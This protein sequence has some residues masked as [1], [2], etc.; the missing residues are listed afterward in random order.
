MSPGSRSPPAR[1]ARF[2]TTNPPAPKNTILAAVRRPYET[3]SVPFAGRP[4]PLAHV[5]TTSARSALARIP[6]R[7]A[8]SSAS[9]PRDSSATRLDHYSGEA[10]RQH[11]P[12]DYRGLP[13]KH[14]AIRARYDDA[15][16]QQR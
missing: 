8:L 13:V 11:V 15:R 5:G 3:K 14:G 2:Q 12:D 16:D 7:L 10:I 4:P 6:C 1:A 9:P